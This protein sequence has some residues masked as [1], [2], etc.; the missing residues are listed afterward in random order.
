MIYKL[1]ESGSGTSSEKKYE[2]EN[3]SLHSWGIEGGCWVFHRRKEG[4]S[5]SHF[6]L[7]SHTTPA[8]VSK[9][10]RAFHYFA[11]SLFSQVSAII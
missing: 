5:L 8:D 4:S 9:R 1:S 10:E 11:F 6:N 7:R 2:H 3:K